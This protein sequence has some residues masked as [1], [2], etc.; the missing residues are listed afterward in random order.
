MCDNDKVDPYFNGDHPKV[1]EIIGVCS[2][3]WKSHSS[4]RKGEIE[5]K[6]ESMKEDHKKRHPECILEPTIL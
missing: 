1:N 2:C 3:G 6:I 5:V 4:Y